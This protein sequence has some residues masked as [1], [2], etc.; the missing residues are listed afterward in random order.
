MNATRVVRTHAVTNADGSRA[1]EAVIPF[2]RDKGF[3]RVYSRAYSGDVNTQVVIERA[4]GNMVRIRCAISREDAAQHDMRLTDAYFSQYDWIWVPWYTNV[5]NDFP[6][7][8]KS[9]RIATCRGGN[10]LDID[11]RVSG[12]FAIT[13]PLDADI[14][15]E[16][17]KG[18]IT[19]LTHPDICKSRVHVRAN[20]V[21][22]CGDD[23]MS[24]PEGER[25]TYY[26]GTHDDA[27]TRLTTNNGKCTLPHAPCGDQAHR[28]T[29]AL[30]RN[31]RND[32]EEE[33]NVEAV[34][35]RR[36]VA[37]A[38]RVRK[39]VIEPH[40][41]RIKRRSSTKHA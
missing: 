34:R 21:N 30:L 17:L 26:W 5:I 36:R 1:Y 10:R 12:L 6:G 25:W 38:R 15:V 40:L 16:V 23:G 2:E 22:I 13:I 7:C 24:A 8:F 3:I 29:W 14:E 31:R 11:L 37:V 35:S 27:L 41:T 20:D 39:W 32:V 28:E 9:E 18:D 33:P 19:Y 4:C